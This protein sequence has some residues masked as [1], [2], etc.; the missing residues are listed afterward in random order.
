MKVTADLDTCIGNGDCTRVCPEVFGVDDEGQ[1]RVLDA[2]P[3]SELHEKVRDAVD[4]CPV[5]ALEIH[6]DA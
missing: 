3:G 5:G 1:V 6:E 4:G 2:E